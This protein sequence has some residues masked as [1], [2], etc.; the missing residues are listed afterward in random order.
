MYVYPTLYTNKSA[1]DDDDD[2][3]VRYITLHYITK[4]INENE[5]GTE[6]RAPTVCSEVR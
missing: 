1:A 6:K 5:N 3:Q 2:D 4:D